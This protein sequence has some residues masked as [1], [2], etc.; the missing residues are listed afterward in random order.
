MSR[1]DLTAFDNLKIHAQLVY[2]LSVQTRTDQESIGQFALKYLKIHII[3]EN[4]VPII[5]LLSRVLYTSGMNQPCNLILFKTNKCILA[6]YDSG[7]IQAQYKKIR[8]YPLTHLAQQI[9]ILGK[10]ESRVPD[11]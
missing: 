5:Q 3:R 1:H 11:R 9:P 10:I 4:L 7:H 8:N 2:S 6:L